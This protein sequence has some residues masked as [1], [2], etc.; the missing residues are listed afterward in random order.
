MPVFSFAVRPVPFFITG[1]R[2]L[3]TNVS[4]QKH[5]PQVKIIIAVCSFVGRFHLQRR[6]KGKLNLKP[7]E[8]QSNA[9]CHPLIV[10]VNWLVSVVYFSCSDLSGVDYTSADECFCWHKIKRCKSLPYCE[11]NVSH[12][13]HRL[14]LGHSEVRT[15]R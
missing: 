2:L 6:F 12:L 8:L 13:L 5:R 1:G 14:H 15:A 11:Y 10:K 9:L 7:L 3:I 4:P